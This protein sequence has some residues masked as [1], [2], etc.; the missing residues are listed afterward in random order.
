V[1]LKLE[2]QNYLMETGVSVLH[3][4]KRLV[5]VDISS[6]GVNYHVEGCALD[7]WARLELTISGK[8][9]GKG[10]ASFNL[11]HAEVDI[12]GNEFESQG[13][14]QLVTAPV[15]VPPSASP[16][17]DPGPHARPTG[18]PAAPL[19]QPSLP[20]VKRI[21][22]LRITTLVRLGPYAVSGWAGATP[23][24]AVWAEGEVIQDSRPCKEK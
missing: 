13:H 17:N 10:K 20:E 4:A 16:P 1:A 18:L 3:C 5:T 2:L 24:I 8:A 14:M 15:V 11:W 12:A 6:L 9:T 21:Q 7:E 23:G 19:P 22:K